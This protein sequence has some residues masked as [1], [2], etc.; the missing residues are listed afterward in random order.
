LHHDNS[1]PHTTAA[2]VGT[3]RK[4]K[5]ERISHPAYGPDLAPSDY[6][7]FGPLKTRY[8]DTD[9][10]TMKRSRTRCLCGFGSNRKHSSQM[11]WGISCTE[12]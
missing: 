10:Q 6:H 3:I 4:L 8:A 1:R 7:I 2:T 12:V 9:L 11:A 5:F